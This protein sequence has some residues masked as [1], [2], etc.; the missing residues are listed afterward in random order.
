MFSHQFPVG[1]VLTSLKW[2]ENYVP[3]QKNPS[4]TSVPGRL[5]QFKKDM[6]QY[7]TKMNTVT[8]L[9]NALVTV[10]T[11][12]LVEWL[13]SRTRPTWNVFTMP[14]NTTWPTHDYQNTTNETN[15]ND[16]NAG[17]SLMES[18][19]FTFAVN[20]PVLL[21]IQVCG[22]C[23]YIIIMIAGFMLYCSTKVCTVII[24]WMMYIV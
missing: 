20:V 8:S 3:R 24:N 1:L 16:T 19:Q 17:V 11:L 6:H 14:N 12:W 4:R 5:F 7:R 23:I 21:H 15:T 10:F 9:W 22:F 2:W 18:A 13:N